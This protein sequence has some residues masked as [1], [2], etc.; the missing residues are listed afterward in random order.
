M[1]EYRD[2]LHPKV[3]AMKYVFHLYHALNPKYDVDFDAID[4]DDVSGTTWCYIVSSSF[5]SC[6]RKIASRTIKHK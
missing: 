6:L 4:H 3:M 1:E 5:V 2:K